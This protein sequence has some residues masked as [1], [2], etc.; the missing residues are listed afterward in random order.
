ML[1][2]LNANLAARP[3]VLGVRNALLAPRFQRWALLDVG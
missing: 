3:V 1:C 2:R